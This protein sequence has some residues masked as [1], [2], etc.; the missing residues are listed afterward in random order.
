MLMPPTENELATRKT[1][2][3]P[4]AIHVARV[5]LVK[6]IALAHRDRLAQLYEHMRDAGDFSPD[7]KLAGRR[8]LRNA[9]LALS[10]RRG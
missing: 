2:A 6:A 8:A 9:G 5:T 10:H 4:E 3:D 7:S 1:P